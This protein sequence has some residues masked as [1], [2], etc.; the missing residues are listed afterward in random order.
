MDCE[1]GVA[2]HLVWW[3][4]Q[5][6]H[7]RGTLQRSRRQQTS[8]RGCHARTGCGR[9]G[10]SATT[11]GRGGLRGRWKWNWTTR[12]RCVGE[13][14]GGRLSYRLWLLFQPWLWF[15]PSLASLLEH[16]CLPWGGVDLHVQRPLHCCG[17]HHWRRWTCGRVRGHGA[18]F[19]GAHPSPRSV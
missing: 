7:W 3:A 8:H 6:H 12:Y 13:D 5:H 4:V 15:Q 19:R 11:G 18:A 14:S 17:L 2:H 10:S 1:Q 9:Y 16:V